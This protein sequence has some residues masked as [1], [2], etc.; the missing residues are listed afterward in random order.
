MD[1]RKSC[2]GTKG[3]RALKRWAKAMEDGKKLGSTV[4]EPFGVEESACIESVVRNWRGPTPHKKKWRHINQTVKLTAAE[5]E[6]EG[7]IIPKKLRTT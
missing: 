5:R 6:S 1:G 7:F 3:S 2:I 4:E